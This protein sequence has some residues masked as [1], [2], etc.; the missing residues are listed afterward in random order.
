MS[1]VRTARAF[2]KLTRTLAVTGVRSDGYH[3]LQSEMVTVSLADE[4]AITPTP[5]GASALVVRDEIDWKKPLRRSLLAPRRPVFEVPEGEDNL[6]LRA[7]R[8]AGTHA[9]IEL[10]KRI[11]AGAGLGGG[12]SDAAAVLRDAGHF[13]AHRAAELGADVPFCLRGGRAL[14]SGIGEQLVALPFEARTFVLCTPPFSVSTAAVYRAYDR[15]DAKA[16]ATGASGRNDL[17][18]AA[19]VVEPRL[20]RWRGVLERA[21]GTRPVLAGS[22]STWYVEIEESVSEE[23]H[24]RVLDAVRRTGSYALVELVHSVPETSF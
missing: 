2:A 1:P 4:L 13:D 5:E 8:I 17:E 24:R 16:R 10:T 19:L 9:S 3:L 11:P 18:V 22:G 14:V 7:C 20:S 12:S 15:L 21:T 6:V 23:Q